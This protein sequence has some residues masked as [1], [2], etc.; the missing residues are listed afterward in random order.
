[1]AVWGIAHILPTRGVVRRF[2]SISEDN[3]R[4]ITMEWVAEGLALC[5][6]GLLVVLV[7]AFSPAGDPTA[8]LVVRAVA[9]MALVLG[10]WTFVIGFKTSD[11]P[12]KLCPLVMAVAA[13]L[14]VWG[15]AL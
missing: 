9:A 4:I 7:T 5:F 3:R 11:L 13:V 15:S 12:I 10:G 8:R 14:L 2:G 6:L 1:M